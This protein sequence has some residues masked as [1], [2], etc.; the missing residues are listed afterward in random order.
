MQAGL[1]HLES[2]KQ[3]SGAPH[4]LRSIQSASIR[5]GAH[6]APASGR[7][8]DASQWPLQQ[9]DSSKGSPAE[10]QELLTD[11]T[12]AEQPEG[13]Q[14]QGD[15]QQE[16]QAQQRPGLPAR[17]QQRAGA[18]VGQVLDHAAGHADALKRL[19][20]GHTALAE[21]S[22]AGPAKAPLP[23]TRDTSRPPVGALWCLE[24]PAQL[25]QHSQSFGQRDAVAFFAEIVPATQPPSTWLVHAVLQGPARAVSTVAGSIRAPSLP[26]L[27]LGLQR[28]RST[29]RPWTTGCLASCH[30]CLP[31]PPPSQLPVLGAGCPAA[32]PPGAQPRAP[33][34]A[35]RRGQL[36][37]RAGGLLW[38]RQGPGAALGRAAPGAAADAGALRCRSLHG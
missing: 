5:D 29:A 12:S 6:A 7:A 24:A 36:G 35:G 13:Q 18:Q 11:A 14:Q 33:P 17:L 34:A 30:P 19:A 15:V 21:V 37:C 8:S 2:S 28:C 9:G 16:Q 1:S 31:L 25:Q 22:T 38:R 23:P 26:L 4:P 32:W 27:Q 10:R 3:A 20:T